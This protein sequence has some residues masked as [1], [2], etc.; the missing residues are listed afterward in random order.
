[1]IHQLGGH[2]IDIPV[3]GGDLRIFFPDLLAELE[4][5]AIGGFDNV[6]LSD[7]G[8]P[9]LVVPAGIVVGQARNPL[10]PLSGGDDK[11]ERHILVHIY[12]VGAH[13]VGALCI[14]PEE[15]PVDPLVGHLHRADVGKQV[16]LFAHRHVG[17]LDVGPGVARSGGSGGALQDHMALL[18]LGQYIVGDGFAV[19]SAVFN[20]EPV[21]VAEF[22]LAC[23]HLVR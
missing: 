6:G 9:A 7:N 18:Q 21:D 19:G 3:V 1:M 20:G 23:F 17:T 14:L 4:E 12:A 10:G 11:V 5:L 16:Q 8:D 13:C 22:H 15:G 2:D